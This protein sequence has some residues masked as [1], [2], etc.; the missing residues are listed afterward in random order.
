MNAAGVPSRLFL[1]RL[2]LGLVSGISCLRWDEFTS[3][4]EL[5]TA[6]GDLQEF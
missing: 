4:L 2:K 5:L 1:K 3:I 6:L